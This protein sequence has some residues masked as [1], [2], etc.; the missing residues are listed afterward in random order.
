MKTPFTPRRWTL[1]VLSAAAALVLSGCAAVPAGPYAETQVPETLT[2]PPV[3]AEAVRIPEGPLAPVPGLEPQPAVSALPQVAVD[4]DDIMQIS[5]GEALPRSAVLAT[6]LPAAIQ[7]EDGKDAAD[8]PT[9]PLDPSPVVQLDAAKAR[10]DLWARL[11]GGF[12]LNDLQSDLVRD[13]ERWYSARPEYV[14]RMTE[15]GSRYLYHILQ[16]V[17]RRGMPTELA[18]LPFIE[19][20]YN[21]QAMSTAKA[22]GM[23]QFIPSTGLDYDLKQNIFRDDRRDVLAS[24]Q[25]ALDYLQRLNKM[26]GD[27]HLALA[28]YNWGE[29][30]VQRAINRNLKA[31][32]ATDYESLGMPAETRS[33]VPK[34]Q[35]VK[36]IVAQPRA[37]GLSLPALQNHPY[38]L[39]VALRRDID[40]ALAARMAGMTLDE[41]KTL[42]P[43][44]NKPVILAAGTPQ[45]LLPYD[46]AD[47][48]KA[49]LDGYRGPLA[50]WTAWVVPRTMHPA[51]AAKL[52]AMDEGALREI[53][54]IPARMLVKA[55]S[56]LLVPRSEQRTTDV[57]EHVADNAQM[58]L[59]P[60]VPPLRKV[61]VKTRKG[62]TL[63]SVAKRYRV[64]AAQLAQWNRIT[65]SSKLSA[66]QSLVMY[67][68]PKAKAAVAAR[69]SA[70][71]AS[72]KARAVK[73]AGERRVKL[74][75]AR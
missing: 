34:L 48:F 46:N 73:P 40:T 52:A 71:K 11:R 41:F 17:E 10:D 70:A 18:L 6:A 72:G 37:Y 64:S 54:R 22:S 60:D 43:Q 51:E 7:I 12:R 27:W 67:Q 47:R 26:F 24:T 31:G 16:E 45:L 57:S 33:Y 49:S 55:G 56:T 63:A 35:A 23:W 5:H 38:F 32:R 13:N 62:D 39:S 21:P 30:N 28:A 65:T 9:D 44:L 61:A 14:Q 2:P 59:A 58:A 53:N 36:N 66:G 1:S 69:T 68:A 75:S 4:A 42:N 74:A 3:V 8:A 50:T 15:R 19:S 20:A 25:A 29:G